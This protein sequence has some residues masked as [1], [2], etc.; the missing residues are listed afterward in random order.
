MSLIEQRPS[1]VSAAL[2]KDRLG[3]P[4]VVFFVISAAAPL[5]VVAGSVPTAYAV[6]G[7]IGVPFAFLMLGAIFTL[8]AVGYVTMARHVVNA[9]AFYAYAA[10]GLGRT[11]GVATA[12]VALLAYN[13]LQ[14]GLYGIIG[15]AAEPLLKDWFGVSP[16]W[17]V[18]ALVAWALVGVLGLL[19]VDV[20][21]KIL[22]VLLASE[23]AVVLVFDLGD[24]LNA[25][26][27][28]VTFEGFDPGALFVPGVGAALA[29]VV[30]GFAGVESSV[31]FAEESKDRDRTVPTATYVGVA[32]IAIL[33]AISAWAQTVP[34]G[35]DGIVKASTEQGT[36][37]IF[38]QATAHMGSAVATIGS[39]LFVTSSIACMIAFHNTTARYIFA[40]GRENVLPQV[41]GRTSARTA[42]PVTGSVLQTG[43]GLIVITVYAVFGLDPVTKLFFTFGAFGGL[44]LLT[45]LTVTSIAVIVFFSRNPAEET[46][47]RTRIAPALAALAL[48]VIIVL[49]LVNF[50]T[51]LGVASDSPIRWILP[52]IFVV[53]IVLGVLWAR[54]L[55]VTRPEVYANIGLGARAASGDSK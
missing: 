36:M 14:L 53:A 10:Q 30:A 26:P 32:V 47:W 39:L 41:F 2:A 50:D 29:T 23:I 20:N 11:Q 46:A 1:A 55:K 38:N 18:I 21:G 16:S 52:G 22:S 48:T 24:L 40:L 9:G 25:G 43:L 6:T 45:L 51:V 3:V 5:M 42:A 19:R 34:T 44:G 35:P 33:Y 12:W 37:L 31:V 17:W 8:F 28:G 7:V 15:S 54:V 27:A 13:A 4:S 49:T